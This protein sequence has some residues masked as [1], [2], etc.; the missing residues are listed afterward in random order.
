MQL[1]N[2]SKTSKS[3]TSDC[4]SDEMFMMGLIVCLKFK[5]A[6]KTADIHVIEKVTK[7]FY[8]YHLTGFMNRSDQLINVKHAVKNLLFK[9]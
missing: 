1:F 7:R 9:V 4:E 5:M 6:S 8:K 3:E 2:A